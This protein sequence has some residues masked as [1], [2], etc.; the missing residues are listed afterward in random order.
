[1]K[2]TLYTKPECHLCDDAL[3]V[4]ERVRTEVAFE[5]E[6]VDI[7]EDRDAHER[8]HQ[9]VPVVVVDEVE[10]FD[11]EVDEEALRA[12]A[13]AASPRASIDGKRD[14]ARPKEHAA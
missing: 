6:Q 8:Y 12:M 5:L 14:P 2:V 4:I 7:M 11:Y 9:R 10:V 13:L 3:A 1:M